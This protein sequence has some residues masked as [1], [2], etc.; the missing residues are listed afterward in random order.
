MKTP[1]FATHYENRI[2]TA[3][4][5]TGKKSRTLQSDAEAA[6][7]NNILK[8]YQ[9]TGLLPEMIKTN[10][11]YG[12]FADVPSYQE[13]L[14]IVKL[15]H[16]QFDNLDAH[17]RARFQNSP[18]E[19]LAFTSNSDNLKEMVELGLAIEKKPE[20]EPVITPNAEATK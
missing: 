9:R 16:E 17:V 6:D 14:N 5:F 11:R 18:E 8:R 7:I 1:K 13:A 15:A 12:E 2:K 19:F 4:D 3:L 20:I 10:P